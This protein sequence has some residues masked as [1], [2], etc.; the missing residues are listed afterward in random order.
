MLW[1][2]GISPIPLEDWH[3]AQVALASIPFF[4]ENFIHLSMIAS[5]ARAASARLAPVLVPIAKKAGKAMIL[6]AANQAQGLVT[7]GLAKQAM[8]AMLG[9]KPTKQATSGKKKIKPTAKHGIGKR[10]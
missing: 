6:S 4:Y 7:S 1:D 10:R 5:A 9:Q 3:R 2:I 8:A